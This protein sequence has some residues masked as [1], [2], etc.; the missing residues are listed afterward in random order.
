M[1][2]GGDGGLRPGDKGSGAWQSLSEWASLPC[3]PILRKLL[4]CGKHGKGKRTEVRTIIRT[5]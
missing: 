4:C 5:S 2:P 3:P 1:C